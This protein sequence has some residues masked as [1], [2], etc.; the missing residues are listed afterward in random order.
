MNRY[1]IE[2]IKAYPFYRIFFDGIFLQTAGNP[3]HAIEIHACNH[4]VIVDDVSEIPIQKDSGNL[5]YIEKLESRS[6][7]MPSLNKSL[8]APF[9]KI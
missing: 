8:L 9:S 7:F 1:T 3:R 4:G 6:S 5:A 2:E